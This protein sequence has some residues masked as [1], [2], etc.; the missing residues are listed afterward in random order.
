MVPDSL[1]VYSK[2]REIQYI[3]DQDYVYD[4]YWGTIKRHPLGKIAPG[5]EL[6]LDYSV[7]LCRYDALVLHEDGTIC[8]VEGDSEAPESRELL[9][10]EPPAV[11]EGFVLAHIFTGWGQDCIYGGNSRVLGGAVDAPV[12]LHGRYEDMVRRTYYVE[13]AQD[14]DDGMNYVK[15]AATGEDYGTNKIITNS[16]LRW[17]EPKPFEFGQKLPLLVK[18]AYESEVDWGLEL[19]IEQPSGEDETTTIRYEIEAI[20]EM[21]FD[22][23]HLLAGSNPIDRIPLEQ[24]EHLTGFKHSLSSAKTARIAFFGES[25]TRSGLWT[26]QL[27]RCLRSKY[28][29]TRL[30]SSNVAIGGEGTNRG[31]HRLENEVLN[32]QPNLIILEYLINDACSGDP[33]I[34]EKNIRTILE[35]IKDSGSACLVV[36]NNGVNPHFTPLGAKRNFRLYHELYRRLAAEYKV[37]FVGGYAYFDQLHLYGKY[38]ITELK[39]NMVNHPYGNVDIT[40]GAFD[41]VLSDA[42]LKA[43]LQ[44]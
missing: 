29:D 14:L 5:E 36:T 7:W 8:V 41:R 26:Y 31:I 27:M 6:S 2:N 4:F 13:I 3:P 30:Y 39:G 19:E 21:I 20:P 28:P 38:F 22:M 37:A 40:W 10:P 44:E 15:L 32:V 23:R 18:T 42:I 1:Y 16:T 43:I 35:R 17:T 12:L 33:E 9:L 34:T 11:R 24:L 25:T